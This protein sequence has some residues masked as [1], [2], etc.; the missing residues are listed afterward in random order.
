MV[1]EL[2]DALEADQAFSH[3]NHNK[4]VLKLQLNQFNKVARLSSTE[5]H[6]ASHMSTRTFKGTLLCGL[7]L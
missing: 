2:H 4:V 6:A 3:S 7:L 5:G 1:F